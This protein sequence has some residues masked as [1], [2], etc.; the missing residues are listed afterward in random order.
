LLPYIKA[1][2]EKRHNQTRE[3]YSALKRNEPSSHEK[4]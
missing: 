1:N 4:T 2:I 3:Y